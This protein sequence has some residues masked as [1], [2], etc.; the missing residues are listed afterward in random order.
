[1]LT[2]E[3][4]Y[5]KPLFKKPDGNYVLDLI[6]ATVRYLFPPE[7]QRAIIV[8]DDFQMR[9][10]LISG[11]TMGDPSKMDYILKLNG[12]SNPLSIEVGDILLIPDV[13]QMASS[14]INPDPEQEENVDKLQLNE[15]KPT[16]HKD[17]LR[18]EYLKKKNESNGNLLP[19]NMK[20][21]LAQ[22]IKFKE[23][24][25]IF[26]EDVTNYNKADCPV[27]LT[28]ARVKER[29]LNKKIFS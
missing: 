20:N 22:N 3:T 19:P 2:L 8:S 26:G 7:Y 16:L 1:M 10:D 25:I 14:F 13:S 6:K 21:D 27:V 15:N 17:K 4:L 12:V 28:R 11:A 23:G 29:L 9:P 5:R 18:A 24:K